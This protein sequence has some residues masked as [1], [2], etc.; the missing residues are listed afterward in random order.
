MAKKRWTKARLAGLGI[1]AVLIPGILLAVALGWN[2]IK[3]A[4]VTNYRDIKTIFPD[5]G[6]V[7]HVNDGDTFELVQAT[8]FLDI[9]PS[10]IR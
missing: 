9:P 6:I 3:L 1:P 2:P 8:D 10:E 4:N 7:S 5:S